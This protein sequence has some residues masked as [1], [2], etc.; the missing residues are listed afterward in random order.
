MKQLYLLCLAAVFTINSA[1]GA[2]I[3]RS[4]KTDVDS[5]EKIIELYHINFDTEEVE[6]SIDNIVRLQDE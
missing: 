4:Y 6:I 5:R 2:I 3:K 1:S